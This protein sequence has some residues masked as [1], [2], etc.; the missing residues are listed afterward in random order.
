[1]S[2]DFTYQAPDEGKY[3][4]A[5]LVMLRKRGYQQISELLQNSRCLINSSGS[6]SKKRWNALYTSIIFQIPI[7]D[8]ELLDINDQSM[9]QILIEICNEVMPTEIGFDV[10]NVE[11]APSLSSFNDNKALE[12]DL[13]S[14]SKGLSEI[15]AE[16]ILPLDVM[17]KGRAMAETYLY[18]YAIENY[19]RLFVDKV[20]QKTHG[21]SYWG[22]LALPKAMVNSINIRKDQEAKNQWIGIRGDSDL[23]YLDFKELG[24]LISNNWEIF[25]SYFP[26]QHWI[27]SKVDELGN[28]R[29]LVAHNSFLGDHERDVIRVNFRSIVRQLNPLMK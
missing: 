24:T 6:Y 17:E 7:D 11:F 13:L 14:I 25:K 29:N 26:D 19:L 18:L 5:I 2:Q 1:M 12:N 8:F 27:T 15:T 9:I 4:K 20:G 3:F 22:S 23:F 10:L 21:A 28:C 16:F